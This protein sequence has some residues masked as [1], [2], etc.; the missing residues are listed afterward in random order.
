MHN[1]GISPIKSS[2]IS[3][4]MKGRSNVLAKMREVL[5]NSKKEALI[6]TSV[7]DFEDKSRVLLP[8]LEKLMKSNVKVR[9][10]LSGDADKIKKLNTKHSLKARQITSNARMFMSDK[11]EV[12]FMVTCYG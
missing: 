4:S 11:K 1:T 2:D 12:L 6:C 3:G 8:A 10:A 7:S 9:I 5:S